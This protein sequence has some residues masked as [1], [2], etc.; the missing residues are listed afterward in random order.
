MQGRCAV[1]LCSSGKRQRPPDS[2]SCPSVRRGQRPLDSEARTISRQGQEASATN[3]F[4][5]GALRK[6]MSLLRQVLHSH[7]STEAELRD[8]MCPPHPPPVCCFHTRKKRPLGSEVRPNAWQGQRPLDSEVWYNVRRGHTG[9]RI[10]K[11]DPNFAH[12]EVHP[13]AGQGQRPSNSEV[14]SIAKQR[15]CPA[16]VDHST[17][18]P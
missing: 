16:K 13:N 8:E 11:C 3:L 17:Q 12:S 2:E 10:V 5:E 14:W 9:P 15:K 6:Q 1:T 7:E 18:A 4:T